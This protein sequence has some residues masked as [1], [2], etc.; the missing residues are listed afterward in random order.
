MQKQLI[1]LKNESNI[2]GSISNVNLKEFWCNKAIYWDS[3]D[4][5][6]Y[7]NIRRGFSSL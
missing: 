5:I 3:I 4:N 1:E 2:T 7:L 6:G